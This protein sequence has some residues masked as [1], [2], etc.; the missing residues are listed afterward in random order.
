M[1]DWAK[2]FQSFREKYRRDD[3]SMWSGAAIE[4]ATRARGHEVSRHWVYKMLDG[5]IDNP[6]YFKIYF[7]SLVMGIPLPQWAEEL[8]ADE[9]E[10]GTEDVN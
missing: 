4:R 9:K 3:G 6:S 5:Q 7:V 10:E 8:L 2:V 1:A